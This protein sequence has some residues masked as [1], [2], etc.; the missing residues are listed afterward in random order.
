MNYIVP[1]HYFILI[2]QNYLYLYL[3]RFSVLKYKEGNL[4]TA[5]SFLFFLPFFK[6]T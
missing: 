4:M 3:L 2:H 5:H 1:T 6:E